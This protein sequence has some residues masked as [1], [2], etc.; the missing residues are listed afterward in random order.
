M[1]VKSISIEELNWQ[2]INDSDVMTLMGP[3]KFLA[4]DYR[5]LKEGDDCL[6]ISPGGLK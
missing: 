1:I 2:T 4:G 5:L 3:L 6:K